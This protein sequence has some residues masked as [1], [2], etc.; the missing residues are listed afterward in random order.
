MYHWNQAVDGGGGGKEEGWYAMLQLVDCAADLAAPK[1][2]AD[3]DDSITTLCGESDHLSLPPPQV[4]I[5]GS[6]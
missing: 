4:W 6:D 5:R 2:T 3:R 1:R